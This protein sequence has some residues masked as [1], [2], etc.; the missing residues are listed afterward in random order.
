MPK[1]D[2]PC[3]KL[4]K[5]RSNYTK[6]LHAPRMQPSVSHR[7]LFLY[8]SKSIDQCVQIFFQSIVSCAF[9]FTNIIT[10]KCEK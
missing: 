3:L 5:S 8:I 2:K 1:I 10:A 4:M 7:V 6:T 9:P